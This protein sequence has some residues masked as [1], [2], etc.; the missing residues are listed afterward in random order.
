MR[1]PRSTRSKSRLP[2]G[3]L[4]RSDQTKQK[5]IEA[6]LDLLREMPRI[7]TAR[8]IA[9]RAGRSTRSVFERFPDLLT[10]SF[11]AAD[12]AFAPGVVQ[13]AASKA[14]G[15]RQTRLRSHVETRAQICEHWLPLWRA[16]IRHESESPM[17]QARIGRVY[18]LIVER[19]Q[20][21]YRPELSTLAEPERRQ[22]LIALEALTDFQI[23]G[24]D[25]RASWPF[26]RGGL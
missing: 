16:L 13:A 22:V 25:A 19:L 1:Q 3:R 15:D 20:L 14:D 4:Q 26:D 6:Y 2:D 18:D 21:M 11:A 12:H 24:P 5:L 17:L 23:V 7:P 9:E 10:L 8:Q